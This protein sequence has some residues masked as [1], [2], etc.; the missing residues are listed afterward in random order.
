MDE[1]KPQ[2]SR[3]PFYA[4]LPA[5]TYRKLR[6]LAGLSRV[7]VGKDRKPIL[8]KLP[9]PSYERLRRIAVARSSASGRIASMLA[10]LTDMIDDCKL[11]YIPKCTDMHSVVVSLIE[12]TPIRAPVDTSEADQ[13][14]A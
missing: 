6:R 8:V 1:A 4:R 3:R 5:P 2:D 9:P 11:E 13:R 14:S 7:K 12:R 10:V